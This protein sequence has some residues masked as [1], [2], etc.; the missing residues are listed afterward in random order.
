MVIHRSNAIFA[1]GWTSD[2]TVGNLY[3]PEFLGLGRPLDQG[4]PGK[5]VN[6][7]NPVLLRGRGDVFYGRWISVFR[8]V[9]VTKISR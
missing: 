2:R 1:P 3:N 4:V 9:F 7:L 5:T 8:E 6:T